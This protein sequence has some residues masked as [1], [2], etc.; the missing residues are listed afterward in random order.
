M[1]G[2]V[3]VADYKSS[4]SQLLDYKSSRTAEQENKKSGRTTGISDAINMYGRR[5]CKKCY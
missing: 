2:V 4:Y 5:A 3:Y 1:W